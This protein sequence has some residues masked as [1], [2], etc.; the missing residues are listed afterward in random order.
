MYQY[1]PPKKRSAGRKALIWVIA[2]L[3]V[4]VG[5]DFGAKAFAESEAATQ[6]QK[7]GFPKKPE[8][9]DRRLPLPDAGHLQELPPG[10]DQLVGHPR[11]AHQDHEPERRRR[12]T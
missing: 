6:I 3:V 8:R 7:Q 1:Q 2:I 11:G 10:H 5:L 4:L 9:V 12:T